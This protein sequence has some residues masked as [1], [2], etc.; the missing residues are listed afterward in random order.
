[1]KIFFL[2]ALLTNIIFFLWEYNSGGL[3]ADKNVSKI[4][5]NRPKQIL[6]LTELPKNTKKIEKI[7]PLKILETNTVTSKKE[8]CYQIG[9]FDDK[10]KVERWRILNRINKSDFGLFNK[11]AKINYYWVYSPPTKN[12]LE[13]QKT[14]KLL[15]E[16]GIK[17]FEIYEKGTFKGYISLGLFSKLVNALSIKAK[18]IEINVNVKIEPVPKNKNVLYIQLITPNENIKNTLLQPGMQKITK[19]IK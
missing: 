4:K 7:S 9:P 6:L 10:N 14:I 5:S 2:L 15:K 16:S 11:D 8:F 3:N 19:C 12:Y 17:D 1:M 13:K 18:M